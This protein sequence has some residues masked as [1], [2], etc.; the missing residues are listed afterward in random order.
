MVKLVKTTGQN[1]SLNA[2]KGESCQRAKMEV[3][4][5]EYCRYLFRN[6][7]QPKTQKPF[8]WDPNTSSFSPVSTSPPYYP[9]ILFSQA[10]CPSYVLFFQACVIPDSIKDYLRSDLCGGRRRSFLLRR[11][12]SGSI[13]APGHTSLFVSKKSSAGGIIALGRWKV[14][15][16]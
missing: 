15:N 12:C 6:H 10:L 4:I 16:L 3:K 8:S 9:R 1:V 14:V 2:F 11:F 5:S 7:S 13:P